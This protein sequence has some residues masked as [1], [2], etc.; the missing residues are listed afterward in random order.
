MTLPNNP[1]VFN[2]ADNEPK[3]HTKKREIKCST[4]LKTIFDIG[5]SNDMMGNHS[6]DIPNLVENCLGFLHRETIQTLYYMGV[7]E[8][9]SDLIAGVSFTT[10]SI[11]CITFADKY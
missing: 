6:H 4:Q 9:V 3:T 10:I 1:S 5:E 11:Q 2:V 8:K 7:N